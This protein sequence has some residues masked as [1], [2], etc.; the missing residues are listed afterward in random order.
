MK[1]GLGL[2]ALLLTFF[3][4]G[5]DSSK[6][7][8]E[9]RTVDKSIKCNDTKTMLGLMQSRSFVPKV[10]AT[11]TSADGGKLFQTIFV[12]EK[13]KQIAVVETQIEDGE[14]IS[15]VVSAGHDYMSIDTHGLI[16]GPFGDL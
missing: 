3:I 13:D 8:S 5:T 16:V 15:C 1:I 6:S 9:M 10:A 7:E 4:G 2:I 12:D 11:L 14:S